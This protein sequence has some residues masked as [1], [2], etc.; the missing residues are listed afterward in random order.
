MGLDMYLDKVRKLREGVTLKELR[1]VDEYFGFKERGEKYKKCSM[2]KWCGI[3]YRDVDRGLAKAYKPEYIHRYSSW[4]TE[5]KYGFKTIFQNIAYWRKAN[6][7][8]KWFVENVQGGTDDCNMYK[9]EKGQLEELLST[10]KLVKENQKLASKLLPTQCGFFFGGTEY[11]EY[12]MEDI[13]HTIKA[14]EKVLKETDFDNW[15]V[16]YVSSW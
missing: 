6:Q 9:V 13:D 16:L 14:L 12:Y 1:N 2:K 15:I 8:H 5:R 3:D 11:D 10:C 4:D 7:I